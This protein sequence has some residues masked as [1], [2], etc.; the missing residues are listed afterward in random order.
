[1]PPVQKTALRSKGLILLLAHG[2]IPSFCSYHIPCAAAVAL[3]IAS[4]HAASLGVRRLDPLL[5]ASSHPRHVPGSRSPR[6]A[7]P[8]RRLNS[9][10]R[11]P[12]SWHVVR[13]IPLR[14]RDGGGGAGG[15]EEGGC[16]RR[17]CGWIVDESTAEMLYAVDP[18]CIAPRVGSEES[19]TPLV[20][21]QGCAD[22]PRRAPRAP[23]SWAV[24]GVYGEGV[25]KGVV[26]TGR[27]VRTRWVR[28]ESLPAR[29][30]RLCHVWGGVEHGRDAGGRWAELERRA[31]HVEGREDDVER[32]RVREAGAA[33]RARGVGATF[34]AAGSSHGTTG[35]AWSSMGAS[36]KG[37]GAGSGCGRWCGRQERRRAPRGRQKL[38]HIGFGAPTQVRAQMTNV[39]DADRDPLK[40]ARG[41]VGRFLIGVEEGM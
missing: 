25:A 12:A 40:C 32:A 4:S 22:A 39:D 15:D 37:A 21:R 9:L 14:D 31:G 29:P 18:T 10:L 17:A 7:T 33:R 28:R 19:E 6:S 41:F 36:S 23:P 34:K 27:V 11:V 38:G 5:D 3:P 2:V 13:V 8:P 16:R 24:C 30:A 26:V 35:S 1:M 20:R